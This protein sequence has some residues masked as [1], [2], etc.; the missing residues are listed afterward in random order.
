MWNARKK[1]LNTNIYFNYKRKRVLGSPVC[2]MQ[3]LGMASTQSLCWS[4][5]ITAKSSSWQSLWRQE[6]FLDGE[7][8]H[9]AH[10]CQCL[11]SICLLLCWRA[12][13][14]CCKPLGLH[15]TW[16]RGGRAGNL[17]ESPRRTPVA[18][19]KHR[20]GMRAWGPRDKV[21][22]SPKQPNK[23]SFRWQILEATGWK[24]EFR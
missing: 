14:K 6:A 5:S 12:L 2:A 21:T 10:L 23:H 9:S 20:C 24:S 17:G 15:C 18:E 7:L 11:W 16:E 22:L 19:E 4:N 13:E 8:E 1:W 3:E